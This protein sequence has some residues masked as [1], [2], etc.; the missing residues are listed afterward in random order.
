MQTA[1]GCLGCFTFALTFCFI[2]VPLV[3]RSMK[4][5]REPINHPPREVFPLLVVSEERAHI[6]RFEDLSAYKTANPDYSFLVPPE[7][8]T[9][10]RHDVE[11]AT[12]ARDPNSTKP[13]HWFHTFRVLEYHPAKQNILVRVD[14][15]DDHVIESLYEATDK[16]FVAQFRSRYFGP[17]LILR[18]IPGA[19]LLNGALWG[20]LAIV[21]KRLKKRYSSPK[22]KAESTHA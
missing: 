15:D 11:A 18:N 13:M 14:P 9:Q 20:L 3:Q 22:E 1:K 5:E 7:K 17:G 8:E 10:Y 21:I 12:A 4:N 6:I 19:L 2:L 16:D